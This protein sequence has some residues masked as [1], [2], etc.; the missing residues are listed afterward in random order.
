MRAFSEMLRTQMIILFRN[1]NF[2][3]ISLG[4]PVIAILAFGF[5]FR[6]PSEMR[7]SV[8][9]EDQTAASQQLV[10]A[11][12]AYPSMVVS[13]GERESELSTLE[14]GE[15]W[16]VLVIPAGFAGQLAGQGAR[17]EVH[18][19]NSDPFRLG[20]ASGALQ[21][22]VD[23]FSDSLTSSQKPV[24]IDQRP[25]AA[26]DLRFVDVLLPGMVGMAIMFANIYAGVW[27]IFWREEG[28]L[29]RLGVTPLRPAT[30]IAAQAIAYSLISTIQV[31]ILLG[32]A[33]LIFDVEVEGSYLL[34]AL[35]AL[36]GIA[37]MLGLGYLIGSY[38]RTAIAANAVANLVTFP[39]M[40]LG[41]SFM[42]VESPP[43]FLQPIIKVLPLHYLNDA[44]REIIN[45]GG[46]LGEVWPS[47]GILVGWAVGTF[48]LS[49][50][51]F[52]WQ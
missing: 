34:L 23:G 1:T 45:R 36:A 44:L 5:L 10:E 33:R 8:V 13:Q 9:D 17:V 24:V 41:G 49:A 3:V 2:W 16:A 52:R 32:L 7:V 40:F 47:L 46:G 18:V 15:R 21:A 11:V 28:I 42:P 25:V 39:M 50:R 48:V 26:R 14:E 35:T 4:L 37:A 30:L 22:V 31:I 29:R 43:A 6:N 27:L 20:T 12:K 38:L 19:D 51:V